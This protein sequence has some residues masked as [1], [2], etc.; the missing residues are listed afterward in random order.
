MKIRSACTHVR[1]IKIS[2]THFSVVPGIKNNFTGLRAIPWIRLQGVWLEQ[3]GF[4][5]G[6]TVKLTIRRKRIVVRV[7]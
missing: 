4:S 3:A 7:E 5:I 1:T 2:Q 6:Q